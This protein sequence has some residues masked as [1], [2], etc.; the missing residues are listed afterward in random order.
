[1]T[2][3]APRAANARTAALPMPAAP[4]VTNATTPIHLLH[5]VHRGAGLARCVPR[6]L[7]AEIP[8]KT[9]VFTRASRAQREEIARKQRTRTGCVHA[10]VSPGWSAPG[11]RLVVARILRSPIEAPSPLGTLPRGRGCRE[12]DHGGRGFRPYE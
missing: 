9:R 4:P 10:R 6:T 2:T 7:F 11:A 3:L 12:G 1:M 8:E 5:L